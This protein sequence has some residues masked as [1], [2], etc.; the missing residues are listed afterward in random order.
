MQLLGKAT[1]H[2]NAVQSAV[3]KYQCGLVRGHFAKKQSIK[4]V[5]GCGDDLFQGVVP[6]IYRKRSVVDSSKL[7]RPGTAL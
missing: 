1:P 3:D 6:H 5:T 4:P 7:E 2:A